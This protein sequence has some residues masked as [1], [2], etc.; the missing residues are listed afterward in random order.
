MDKPI[1][2]LDFD[3]VLHLYSEGWLGL[4]AIYDPSTPG[5]LEFVREAQEHFEVVIYS[6]R[7][8]TLAGRRAIR[9]WLFRHGFPELEVTFEKPHALVTLDDRAIQFTG[10]FPDPQTLLDFKPWNRR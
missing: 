9:V 5:A 2:C 1:L 8:R 3:G 6:T 7:A 10:T 4:T